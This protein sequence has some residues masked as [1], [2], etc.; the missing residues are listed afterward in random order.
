M[1]VSWRSA[2]AATVAAAMVFVGRAEE[3]PGN[4]E[5]FFGDDFDM[6]LS[7]K[8]NGGK[9]VLMLFMAPW[10]NNC[11]ALAPEFLEAAKIIEQLGEI[12]D[13]SPTV[14]AEIDAD[15]FADIGAKYEIEAFPTLKWFP[16]GSDGAT[17][18]PFVAAMDADGMV[19]FIK[20]QS[21]KPLEPI[22]SKS[23]LADFLALRET[24][25]FK[26]GLTVLGAKSLDA[27]T[28]A[29]AAIDAVRKSDTEGMRFALYESATPLAD[30]AEILGEPVG[31]DDEG[32]VVILSPRHGV[33]SFPLDKVASDAADIIIEATS[34][35]S[36]VVE[37][38]TASIAEALNKYDYAVI[39]FYAPWCGY[40][41][42]LAPVY[43]SLAGAAKAAGLDNVLIAKV[44]AT[45]EE[46]LGVEYGIEGFPTL[47]WIRKGVAY[48]FS[49]ERHDHHAM[50]EYI[51]DKMGPTFDKELTSATKDDVDAFF[52]DHK[53]KRAAFMLLAE[54]SASDAIEAAAYGANAAVGLSTKTSTET[55]Q[56]L[57]VEKLPAAIVRNEAGMSTTITEGDVS[58][59]DMDE[60]GSQLNILSMP[61]ISTFS[62][63]FLDEAIDSGTGSIY[64]MICDP[65]SPAL[66][67]LEK[68]A[69]SRS[70][71]E[72]LFAF[73]DPLDEEMD[74]ALEFF[75]AAFEKGSDKVFL[76]AVNAAEIEMGGGIFPLR[77]S[78][79]EAFVS[80]SDLTVA[81]LETFAQD[82][83][84]Q[85]V[86][87]LPEPAEEYPADPDGPYRDD[88][89][90]ADASADGDA[91]V[92]MGD[93]LH[94][95]L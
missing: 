76:R 30:V 50:L 8:L 29:I 31:S 48:D 65:E 11:K 32:L 21:M 23:A 39:K 74:Y 49:N 24:I 83:K 63:E 43:E 12:G 26:D 87:P 68:F 44:D 7:E 51:V 17:A 86:E 33:K 95:E 90:Y 78:N 3:A 14:F 67:I 42:Q 38:T 10:C 88:S 28:E 62:D 69:S 9:N 52:E 13:L 53:G 81:M 56:A 59:S 61:T 71:R 18:E 80:A 6:R 45:A 64:F 84:E 73:V 20:K 16:A 4:Y 1:G 70:R 85:K 22:K 27:A 66:D 57:N 36:D 35:P 15:N 82:V 75:D 92:D 55:M 37:L 47:K 77:N 72:E 34:I 25:S 19:S 5:I 41:Q 60:L 93:A 94:D 2:L 46:E 58:F 54:E 89:Y 79:G 91:S 40:C